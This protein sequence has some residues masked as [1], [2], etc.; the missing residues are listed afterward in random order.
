[1]HINVHTQDIQSTL[2]E[3]KRID[4]AQQCNKKRTLINLDLSLN[5]VSAESSVF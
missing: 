3:A 2:Q 5:G 4:N 1:M